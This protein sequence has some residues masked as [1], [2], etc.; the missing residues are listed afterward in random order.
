MGRRPRA[1]YEKRSQWGRTRSVAEEI[2]WRRGSRR[3]G[4]LIRAFNLKYPNRG[5]STKS[6]PNY[7][8]D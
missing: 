4:D 7:E 3:P 6:G 5:Y 2:Q 8:Y 1:Q